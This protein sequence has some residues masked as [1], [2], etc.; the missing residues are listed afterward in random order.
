MRSPKV[1]VI[2]FHKTGTTSLRW[3]LIRLGYTPAPSRAIREQHVGDGLR[4]QVLR[5]AEQYDAFQD[6]PWPIF[7]R[8]L[9][10][11]FPDSRFILSIRPTEQWLRSAVRHF[12]HKDTPMRERI[13]GAGYGHPVGNEDVYRARYDQHNR[14]VMAYFRDRP[15]DLLVFDVADPDPWTRLC[16]F[17]GAD[18]PDEPFP[19]AQTAEQRERQLS[20]NMLRRLAGRLSGR[21]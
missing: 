4:D 13:Y 9:D 19:R 8:D 21:R 11:H 10:A 6:N 18:I 2:G 14:E 7:Y 5:I 20:G 17:L 15:D 12:G 3:A 16:G 1:F